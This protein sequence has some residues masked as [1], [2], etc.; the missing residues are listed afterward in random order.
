MFD[1]IDADSL[2]PGV[3][4]LDGGGAESVAGDQQYL[5]AIVAVLGGQFTDGGCLADAVDAEK[6]YHPGARRKPRALGRGDCA[7]QHLDHG[8]LQLGRHVLAEIFAVARRL[9]AQRPHQLFRGFD[10]DI[11]GDQALFHLV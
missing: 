6:D 5:F 1:D 2:A 7:A 8:G 9:T 3:E 11:G 4:L 10:A